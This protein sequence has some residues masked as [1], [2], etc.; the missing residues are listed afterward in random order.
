MELAYKVAHEG[1]RPDIPTSLIPASYAKL[2]QD[3]W[4]DKPTDRPS[5]RR[6]LELFRTR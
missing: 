4:L 2:L 1:L 3:C 6:I 5:F